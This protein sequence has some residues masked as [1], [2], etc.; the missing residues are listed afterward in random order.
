MRMG[1]VPFR[2][3]SRDSRA[4]PTGEDTASSQ[5]PGS[6]PAPDPTATAARPQ[7]C[8]LQS[9]EEYVSV[10]DKP[11]SLWYLRSSGPNGL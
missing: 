5:Q 3:T 4:P 1:P 9:R 11:P 10:V 7:A 6:W 8:S 2:E